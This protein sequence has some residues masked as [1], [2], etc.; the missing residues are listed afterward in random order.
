MPGKGF[1]L[2][3]G[4]L[5]NQMQFEVIAPPRAQTPLTLKTTH[6]FVIQ[7]NDSGVIQI[8]GNTDDPPITKVNSNIMM[9]S[10]RILNLPEPFSGNE[11][12]T[13]KLRRLTQTSYHCLDGRE[14]HS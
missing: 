13:K 5:Q 6:G 1:S 14:G 4:N 7:S 3:L 11:A 8:G 10:R 2:A 9:N 12:S